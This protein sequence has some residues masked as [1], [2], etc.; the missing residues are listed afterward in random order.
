M[1]R[2]GGWMWGEET[3]EEED[4]RKYWK[5][6]NWKK[7]EKWSAKRSK[8][9]QERKQGRSKKCSTIYS[10]VRYTKVQYTHLTVSISLSSSISIPP[11]YLPFISLTLCCI[12]IRIIRLSISTILPLTLHLILRGRIV[13]IDRRIILILIQH[14]VRGKRVRWKGGKEIE[15]G[16]EIETVRLVYCTLV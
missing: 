9:Y 7:I 13:D 14:K 16:R 5:L 10:I 3:S 4:I 2:R 6:L 11:L 1:R 15:E 12:S 8:N